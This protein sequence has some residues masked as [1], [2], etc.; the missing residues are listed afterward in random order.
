MNFSPILLLIV[1]PI[2]GFS[3]EDNS[4]KNS[5]TLYGN[6]GSNIAP[7]DR[8]GFQIGASVGKNNNILHLQFL[9]NEELLILQEP[10][11]DK[12]ANITTVS[13]AYGYIFQNK[14]FRFIPS[15]GIAFGKE[16]YRTDEVNII[17]HGGW[18]PYDSY[19]YNYQK[20]NFIGG[21][22]SLSFMLI[23]KSL[24]IGIEPYITIYNLDRADKGVSINLLFGKIN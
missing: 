11:L 16:N 3:Q 6:I 13:F 9:K 19:N 17:H 1:I 10:S 22:A 24:G 5:Y 15:L 4:K 14:I 21:R 23:T 12:I 18:W 8:I 20:T 2:F 7:N